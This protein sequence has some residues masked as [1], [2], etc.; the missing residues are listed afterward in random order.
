[1]KSTE[2]LLNEF[3]VNPENQI[4][5]LK[6]GKEYASNSIS[7]KYK[8][9][10]YG[11]NVQ[12]KIHKLNSDITARNNLVNELPAVAKPYD[13]AILTALKEGV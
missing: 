7:F 13:E 9:F 1:M 12:R 2:Q 5:V 10:K 6:P 8:P 3:L 4:E 11:R